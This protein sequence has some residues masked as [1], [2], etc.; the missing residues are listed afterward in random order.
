LTPMQDE[1][2]QDTRFLRNR[3]RHDLL[4]LLETYNPQFRGRILD[5]AELVT[6]DEAFLRVWQAELRPQLVHEQDGHLVIDRAGWSALPLSMRRRVLRHVVES[7]RVGEKELPF[8][9]LEQ[10]RQLLETGTV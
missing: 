4:P 3:I 10:A 1:S 7:L 2:N 9:V 5:L 6:A 8:A